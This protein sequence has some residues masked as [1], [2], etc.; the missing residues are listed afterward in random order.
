MSVSSIATQVGYNSATY[1]E[2]VF[3]K[4]YGVPPKAYRVQYLTKENSLNEDS[5]GIDFL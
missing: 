1:F 5:Q 4:Q 2:R 3:K